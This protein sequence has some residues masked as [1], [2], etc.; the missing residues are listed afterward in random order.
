MASPA[1]GASAVGTNGWHLGF[2]DVVAWADPDPGL[3]AI[4]TSGKAFLYLEVIRLYQSADG[5]Q[6]RAP[7][8][9]RVR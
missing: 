5:D 3:S 8:G 1:P 2:T 6:A 4:L 7:E 9:R